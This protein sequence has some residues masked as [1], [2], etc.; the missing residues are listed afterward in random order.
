MC[1]CM[2]VCVYY[3]SNHIFIKHYLCARYYTH[4]YAH[5]YKHTHTEKKSERDSS[6]CL[7]TVVQFM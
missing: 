4:M 6:S 5:K 1:V 3:S 2:Y 7:W